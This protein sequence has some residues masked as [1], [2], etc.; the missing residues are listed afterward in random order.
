MRTF[1]ADINKV[2]LVSRFSSR[3]LTE[4]RAGMLHSSDILLQKKSI[5]L[6]DM[7]INGPPLDQHPIDQHPPLT[8]TPHWSTPICLAWGHTQVHTFCMYL[9][10]RPLQHMRKAA[11]LWKQMWK[12]CKQEVRA[13]SYLSL[14]WIIDELYKRK[15]IYEL[16]K[17][18]QIYELY[19]SIHTPL[20]TLEPSSG[21]RFSSA[22]LCQ[23]ACTHAYTY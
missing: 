9:W 3:S 6:D 4:T 13:Y 14:S 11:R 12:D 15:L 5:Y 21:Y 1:N 8:N 19:K 23:R 10:G 20:H 22:N 18:I 2:M 16:H 17:S 7:L